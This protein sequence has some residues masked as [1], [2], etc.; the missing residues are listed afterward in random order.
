MNLWGFSPKVE[1]LDF[2]MILAGLKPGS[3]GVGRLATPG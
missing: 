3:E 2:V 1:I